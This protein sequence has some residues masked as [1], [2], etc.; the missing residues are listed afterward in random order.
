MRRQG[1]KEFDILSGVATVYRQNIDFKISPLDNNSWLNRIS[2]LYLHSNI[3]DYDEVL[4]KNICTFSYKQDDNE[5]IFDAVKYSLKTTEDVILPIFNEV[6]DID[7]CLEYF[8]MYTSSFS[9]GY[10][11]NEK[12]FSGSCEGLVYFKTNNYKKLIEKKEERTFAKTEHFI[13]IGNPVYKQFAQTGFE[14]RCKKNEEVI[15]NEIAKI[16]SLINNPE[17]YNKA[18]GEL[19]QRK[20]ENV[21]LLRI[22]EL[23][24]KRNY[25]PLSVN[26]IIFQ[27]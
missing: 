16:D 19:K 1:Y 4:Y 14:E 7:S 13:K 25:K 26:G 8:N 18:L 5:S 22:Y 11:E 9:L 2:S 17:L 27:K 21:E 3:F 6:M 12:V 20:K 10:N 24:I 23:E 15:Q